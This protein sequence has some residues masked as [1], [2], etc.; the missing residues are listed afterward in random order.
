MATE[1]DLEAALRPLRFAARRDFANLPVVR[2]I[3]ATVGRGLEGRADPRSEAIRAALRGVDDLPL[4]SRRTAVERALAAASAPSE[5]SAPAPPSGSAPPKA[6]SARPKSPARP[7]AASASAG[8][9]SPSPRSRPSSRAA[10]RT[11]PLPFQ[12]PI[13]AAGPLIEAPLPSARAL[14]LAAPRPPVDETTAR[15]PL[16][17]AKPTHP[18]NHVVGV[19]AKTADQMAKKGILTVQDA[20]F[21]LPS[22]YEDRSRVVR[23][24]ALAPGMRATVQGVVAASMLRPMGRKR[25]W[26]MAIRDGTGSLCCRFFRFSQ[27]QMQDRFPPGTRVRVHGAVTFFGAQRQMAHPEVEPV[28]SDAPPD[29][30]LKA[31][32][33]EIDGVPARTLARTLQSVALACAER[34]HDP[35]PASVRS[36]Y[37]LDPLGPALLLA[38]LPKRG[39]GAALR[40]IRRRLA[41]DELFYLQLVLGR[42][43]S[44]RE[45]SPGIAQDLGDGWRPLAERAL[46]F[47]LTG[48]QAR[49]L[50]EIA[51]DLGLPRPMSRLLQGDVGS[52]KTAVALLSAAA[53]AKSGRQA[54]LLA[55]TEILAEQH[56]RNAHAVFSALGMQVGLL[57]GSTPAKARGPLLRALARGDVHLLVG[58]HALL[59]P[60]VGFLDLGL[61]IIDEQHR[62]GVEQRARLVGKRVGL[63]PDVL[64]M[65]ATPIPRTLTLS[66][67]GDLRVSVLDELPPGRSPTETR[68]YPSSRAERAYAEVEAALDAGRQA[69]VV[70]PLVEASEQLDLAAATDALAELEARF[71]PRR[72]GL[73]HGKMTSD[74][75]STVMRSFSQGEIAVLVA[76]TVIEVGVDVP[77]ATVMVIQE[78]DRFGL[79]QLH[80][81]RGRVGRGKNRGLC[82]LLAGRDSERLAVMA[83]TTDGFVI[84]ERDLELRGPGEV[85]GTRQ[86]GLPDLALADLVADGRLLESAKEAAEALLATDPLLEAPE[87]APLV[88][89]VE[90]RF[91]G[92]LARL[93]AG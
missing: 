38:H 31:V 68:V 8:R 78:A 18:L 85:L 71:A 14:F 70:Y 49:V 93:H 74:A 32:Y 28:T 57:T 86:S 41:F 20:L 9:T 44:H 76:T 83:E 17:E 55:P 4:F 47:A 15:V 60:D 88:A 80:Q 46:P 87:H 26:E 79:S 11:E 1:E 21:F 50:D 25:V 77:N 53:V 33:P 52:G 29:G 73:L 58:T 54:A 30:E 13:E 3:E 62:F 65:T 24:E 59:E 63:P 6:A 92:R 67:Y 66:L 89:E 35:V 48:A 69:Y 7:K 19:G 43:R 51:R 5:S 16:A 84:A 40:Q 2:D 10:A 56:S 61:A 91:S 36:A 37:G 90:R 81:L 45:D 82:V 27:R 22:R 64:V 34:V 12:D 23:I 75:K 39:D 72:V 42:V